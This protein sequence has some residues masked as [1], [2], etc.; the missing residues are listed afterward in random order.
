MVLPHRITGI[1]L[2]RRDVDVIARH[3]AVR[4]IV[5]MQLREGVIPG[6]EIDVEV[7]IRWW[8]EGVALFFFGFFFFK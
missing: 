8:D 7:G 4:G 2:P 5:E 1:R 3:I 6:P